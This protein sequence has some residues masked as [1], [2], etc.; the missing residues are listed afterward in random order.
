ME[1]RAAAR[2]RRWRWRFYGQRTL[3]MSTAC[4]GR[5]GAWSSTPRDSPASRMRPIFASESHSSRHRWRT[6]MWS[7]QTTD[8]VGKLLFQKYGMHVLSR[9]R[10]NVSVLQVF[11]FHNDQFFQ[12]GSLDAFLRTKVERPDIG[13]DE[14]QLDIDTTV[15]DAVSGRLG[16]NFLPGFLA[17]LGIGAV[18]AVS[19][20]FE[21][22]QSDSLR[23]RFGGCT[24]DYVLDGFDL[25]WKLSEVVFDKNKSAMKDDGRYY[26]VTGVHFCNEL[27][28]ELLDKNQMKVDLSADLA[29]VGGVKSGLSISKDKQI[30]AKS[31]KK[32]A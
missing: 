16:L 4:D 6:V 7:R 28:F 5:R 24:R 26:I 12:S 13:K 11:A 17:L 20:S 25:D 21:K 19:A 31:N 8:P 23:F 3:R 32:L 14:A 10:E 15:S 1:C 2:M 30:T 29:L 18:N 22:S 9:P 27:T